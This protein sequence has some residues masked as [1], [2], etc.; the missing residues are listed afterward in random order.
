MTDLSV[1]IP[2]CNEAKRLQKT[3]PTVMLHLALMQCRAEVIVVVNGSTDETENIVY[4]M[5][6]TAPVVLRMV[7]SLPGKGSAVRAGML[8]ARGDLRYMADADFATPISEIANFIEQAR[9]ADVVIGWRKGQRQNDPLLRKIIAAGSKLAMRTLVPGIH[10]SQ[11]GF[12]MFTK[13][14]AIDIFSRATVDGYG[15]DAE[16]I[17]MAR[18]R[19]YTIT[20]LPVQWQHDPDSR[21]R[22]LDSVRVLREIMQI[23]RNARRGIYNRDVDIVQI[24]AAAYF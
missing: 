13:L 18:M 6:K 1:I 11:C 5:Q 24:S 21:V 22:T 4:H 12:K 10:D 2:A 15:F 7:N 19:E 14:A 16:A 8:S 23:E 3:L 20:Q 17:Y 9:I